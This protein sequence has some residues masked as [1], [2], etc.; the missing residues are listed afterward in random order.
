[1]ILF[2]LFRTF[3]IASNKAIMF[4]QIC[5]QLMIRKKTTTIS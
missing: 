2:L 3:P 5:D 4:G 1:V